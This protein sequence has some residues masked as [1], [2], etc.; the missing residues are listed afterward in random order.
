MKLVFIGTGYVGLVTGACLAELGHQVTCVDIDPDRI[1]K[2]NRGE[3]V[4]FEPGLAALVRRNVRAGR[5]GFAVGLKG[6]LRGARAVFIAVGTPQASN[7]SADLSY[8]KTA[9]RDIARNLTG[10]A[11]IVDKSTVPVGTS[12]MVR[13]IIK[14]NRRGPF[15]VVSNPEF[16][17]EGNAI[18]DFMKPDRVVIGTDSQRAQRVMAEIYRPLKAIMHF[19]DLPTAELIKYAANSFLAMKLSFINEIANLCEL[20][21]ADVQPVARGIGMD[22]RIGPKF[23]QAGLGFGGSCFPKDVSALN[24]LSRQLG[25]DFKLVKALLAVNQRQKQLFFE[26]IS[27]YFKNNLSGKRIAVLGLAFK[28]N[29]DDVRE[30]PALELI[31]K[32]RKAVAKVVAFDPQAMAMARKKMPDLETAASVAAAVR[33]ADAVVLATE[34]DS[35]RKLPLKKIRSLVKRRII[36]DGRNLL[37]P[38]SVRRAGFRYF[39]IGRK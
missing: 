37:D 5:L 10:Y 13:K 30:S 16:L 39:S 12:E 27:S 32:L 25:F 11:V 1:A 8:V 24:Y 35:F 4:F 2:L 9:A 20:T 26:K 19:T 3:D 22:S 23:L 17:R 31:A 33:G 18:G 38:R 29:T 36:F 7:G 14:T 34:W 28:G 15:D 21:G 6:R